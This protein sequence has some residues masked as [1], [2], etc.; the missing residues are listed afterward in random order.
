MDKRG[1]KTSLYFC[2]LE[3]HNFISIQMTTLKR[4]NGQIPYNKGD[5]LNETKMFY[6][7]LYKKKLQMENDNICLKLINLDIRKLTAEEK[8]V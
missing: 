4:E 3:S 7:N 5:I 1:K 2:N 8:K 6:T